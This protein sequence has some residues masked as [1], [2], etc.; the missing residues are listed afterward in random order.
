MQDVTETIKD[1]KALKEA[2]GKLYPVIGG[3][4][5]NEAV[6]EITSAKLSEAK[7]NDPK[8]KQLKEHLKQ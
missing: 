4:S 6:T 5:L 2:A 7:E 8:T 3:K 1:D